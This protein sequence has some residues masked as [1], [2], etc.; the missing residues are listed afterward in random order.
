MLD[1]FDN[2]LQAAITAHE[3]QDFSNAINNYQTV[4]NGDPNHAEANHRFG[5]LSMQ[6]GE[7]ENSLIFL[8]NAINVNP[9]IHEYWVPFIDALIKLDRL[10]D[11]EMVLD[12]AS[13]LGHD[14]EIF[15]K[16]SHNLELK[17]SANQE[18]D[19]RYVDDPP[20][21]LVS[22]VINLHGR[23]EFE[24]AIEQ[25][26]LLIKD[27]PNSSILMNLQGNAYA[28]LGKTIDAI[29][30]FKKSIELNESYADPH[31]NLGHIYQS[32]DKYDE[33]ITCYKNAIEI[34]PKYYAAYN[35]LGNIYKEIGDLDAAIG[36]FKKAINLKPKFAEAYYNLGTALTEK[37]ALDEAMDS[38]QSALEIKP[39]N[40]D[41]YKNMGNL[42]NILKE[43]GKLE[44]AIEAYKKA[45][46]IDPD[47]ADGYFN[48]SF[49]K[50]Q[51]EQWQHGIELQ[52]WRWKTKT[53][54]GYER[55]FE[56]PEWDG[57]S[58]IEGKTLLVWGEQ[59]PG[60]MIIWSACLDYYT[61]IGVNVIVECPRKL[62]K[63]LTISFPK[64]T[65]RTAIK[66]I[67]P[68][69]EDFDFQISIA[70]LFGHACVS[71]KITNRQNTYIFPDQKRVQYW[72]DRLKLITEKP[73]IG[74]SWKSPV[75][76]VSRRQNYAD[77]SF[78]K[79]LLQNDNYTFFNLQSLDFE[80]DLQKISQDFGVDVINFDDLDHFD[81]LAEV[82]A[83][84]K[85]LDKTISI[86]TTVAHI[87]TAVGT[88]TII[89]TWKQ[90][91]WNNIL[92]HSRG[93]KTEVFYRNTWESWEN[94]FTNIT[95]MLS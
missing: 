54:Q 42:G 8:Q 25:T 23:S 82:A 79:P 56:A 24:E 81:D 55:V 13:S 38:F 5:I 77:L 48:L 75:M 64:I 90:S 53:F 86:A 4:L 71:G 60:D 45:I 15:S 57:K 51:T 44:E 34:N 95:K 68:G 92:Y 9:N 41:F 61:S 39:N 12:Q 30:F 3:Q 58:S 11:A 19:S 66:D 14:Q 26:E 10:S 21:K 33:A 67:E 47:F 78:W 91:S 89:P 63:L 37:G 40:P 87:S 70:T 6:L 35:N 16:L 88:Q 65:V 74:I 62:V 80:D 20:P 22:V 17:K 27:Y 73:C 69:K 72:K 2:A 36:S 83:F 52:K 29:K 93:P 43:Q 49:A 1:N 7:I 18:A 46:S 85:A 94:T 28:D 50:L 76:T 32:D 84:S 31:Y 59:G